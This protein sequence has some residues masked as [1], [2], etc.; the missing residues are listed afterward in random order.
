MSRQKDCTCDDVP[1]LSL[2]RTIGGKQKGSNCN[3]NTS[4]N[5]NWVSSPHNTIATKVQLTFQLFWHCPFNCLY[6]VAARETSVPQGCGDQTII[7]LYYFFEVTQY[8]ERQH[9]NSTHGSTMP[10]ANSS[11]FPQYWWWQEDRECTA[12]S[13]PECHGMCNSKLGH[14]SSPQRFEVVRQADLTSPAHS[15]SK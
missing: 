7:F 1:P 12:G 2:E 15:Y 8:M 6:Q 10:V 9:S 5:T 4:Q 3:Y 14:I 11:G 13:Y